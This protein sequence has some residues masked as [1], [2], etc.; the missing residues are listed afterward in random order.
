MDF[1]PN[2]STGRNSATIGGV[3]PRRMSCETAIVD[4]TGWSVTMRR[5]TSTGADG[6]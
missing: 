2:E 3:C 1:E 6:A 5:L 4:R